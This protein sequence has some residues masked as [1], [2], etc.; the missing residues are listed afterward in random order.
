LEFVK[1]DPV[2]PAAAGGY[3][4]GAGGAQPWNAVGNLTHGGGAAGR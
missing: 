1:F 3:D 2:V 4:S